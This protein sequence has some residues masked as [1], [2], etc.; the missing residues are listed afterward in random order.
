MLDKIAMQY[1]LLQL[2]LP[3]RSE[4]AVMEPMHTVAISPSRVI[5]LSKTLLMQVQVP[6]LFSQRA[7]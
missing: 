2:L 7:L 1:S 3:I 4:L 5:P 6:F